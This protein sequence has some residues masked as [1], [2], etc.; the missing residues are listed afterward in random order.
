MCYSKPK[1]ISC[2]WKFRKEFIEDFRN[3]SEGR[4]IQKMLDGCYNPPLPTTSTTK[5]FLLA[6]QYDE[7][8]KKLAKRGDVVK[9]Y[10]D[11]VKSW[12]SRKTCTHHQHMGNY[13]AIFKDKHLSWFFFQSADI[14]DM[15]GYS[16]ARHRKCIDL[17]IIKKTLCYDIKK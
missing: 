8:T 13:K 1:E 5:Y 9:I 15:T 6:C 11:C 7:V 3:Y 17:V 14:P 2:D 10:R 12:T 4:E 16:P